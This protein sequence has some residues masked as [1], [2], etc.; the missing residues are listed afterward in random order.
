VNTRARTTCAG[1]AIPETLT[2]H[3]WEV[4]W[5][6]GSGHARIP[7]A[8]NAA[9]TRVTASAAPAPA[10]D[11]WRRNAAAPSTGN[12]GMTAR[13]FTT[14]RLPAGFAFG[15]VPEALALPA[16]AAAPN[17]DDLGLVAAQRPATGRWNCCGPAATHF[18]TP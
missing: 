2:P 4:W 12:W 16:T 9:R 3:Y 13:L 18:H 11:L 6:D 1:G 15:A 8:I 14:L 5:I 17:A 7:T 10:D